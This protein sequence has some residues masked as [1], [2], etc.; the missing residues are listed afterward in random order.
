MGKRV[1]CQGRHNPPGYC[2]YC[3]GYFGVSALFGVRIFGIFHNSCGGCLRHYV[4]YPL[5]HT[6]RRFLRSGNPAGEPERLEG[7]T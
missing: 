3:K 7:I 2:C 5:V 6:L 4:S 1:T